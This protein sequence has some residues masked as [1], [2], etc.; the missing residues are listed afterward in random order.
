MQYICY[1]VHL[2]GV[3]EVTGPSHLRFL[4]EDGFEPRPSECEISFA[5]WLGRDAD[6]EA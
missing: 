5:F 2:P 3:G 1:F 6:P 4:D